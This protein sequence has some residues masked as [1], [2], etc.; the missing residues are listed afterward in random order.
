MEEWRD[1][2]GEKED[3]EQRWDVDSN[4]NVFF[5]IENIRQL[6]ECGFFEVQN[7]E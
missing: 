3:K 2:A 1:C 5:E 7:M 4:E 6:I